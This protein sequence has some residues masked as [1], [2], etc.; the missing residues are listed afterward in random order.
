MH[1]GRNI[2][3]T[4]R[5]KSVLLS[6]PGNPGFDVCKFW[7]KVDDSYLI[8]FIECKYSLLSSQTKLSSTEVT[9]KLKLIR[10][11]I[12]PFLKGTFTIAFF[13]I[14]FYSILFYSILFYSILF[15]SILFYSI[16][17]YLILLF[18]HSFDTIATLFHFLFLSL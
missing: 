3:P 17:F 11:Q 1:N 16:L 7:P 5:F 15:Y 14:L 4:A 18:H 13:S 9:N 6:A 10:D 8:A 12:Q 2:P